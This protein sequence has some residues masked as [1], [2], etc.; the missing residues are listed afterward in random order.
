MCVLS[1]SRNILG[2]HVSGTAVPPVSSI[3][4]KW[5]RTYTIAD[6]EAFIASARWR[7]AWTYRRYALHCYMRKADSDEAAWTAFARCVFAHSVPM[8]WRGPTSIVFRYLDIGKYMYWCGENEAVLVNHDLIR[9]PDP[10][11]PTDPL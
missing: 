1:L 6:T 4:R 10:R 9:D 11:V 8:H 7:Y 3:V 5:K 2:L